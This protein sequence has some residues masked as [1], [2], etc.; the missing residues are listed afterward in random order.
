MPSLSVSPTRRTPS[1]RTTA[2]LG[3]APAPG[4][5]SLRLIETGWGHQNTKSEQNQRKPVPGFRFGVARAAVVFVTEALA[6]SGGIVPGAELAVAEQEVG[7]LWDD[8]TSAW[9][10]TKSSHHHGRA[11]KLNGSEF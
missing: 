7:P 8:A 9:P 3:G 5:G 1:Q 4:G 2:F 10:H 11:A 6:T